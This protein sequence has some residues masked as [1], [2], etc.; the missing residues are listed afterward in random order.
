M[1]VLYCLLLLE[2][3]ID[4]TFLGL[5]APLSGLVLAPLMTLSSLLLCQWVLQSLLLTLVVVV[6][7]VMLSIFVLL[8][9]LGWILVPFVL[10]SYMCMCDVNFP[11]PCDF[12][13]CE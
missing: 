7:L 2:V 6:A 12:P 3:F 11:F 5:L 4:V 10:C 8:I 13:K 9:E 1:A